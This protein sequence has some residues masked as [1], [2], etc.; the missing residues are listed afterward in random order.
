M[1][2]DSIVYTF[3]L[4]VNFHLH[5]VAIDKACE[6]SILDDIKN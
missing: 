2:I 1:S 3:F 5:Y 4:K 6:K